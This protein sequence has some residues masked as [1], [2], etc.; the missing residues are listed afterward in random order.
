MHI[1]DVHTHLGQF[2]CSEM[3][4]DGERLCSLLRLGGITHGICF[5]GEACFGGIDLGNRYTVRE[6]EKQGMLSC[7]LVLHPH[8]YRNSVELL[9]EFADH[10]RVVGIKIHPERGLYD[11]LDR[12]LLQ[13]IEEEIA[14]RNLPILSHVSNNAPVVTIDRYLKLAAQFPE[15]HFVAAHMGTGVAGPGDTSVD[16]WSEEKPT[17]IWF[18]LGTLRAFYTGEILNL[19]KGVGADRLCFGTD[20]PL[21]WPPAF[22]R[23]LETLNLDRETYE[24]IMWKNALNVFPRLSKLVG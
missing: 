5:S 4:A 14:P 19:L 18:D 1:I 9:R 20:A 21:Y 10:P 11:V 6:V 22:T 12:H 15:L 23:T 24:K 8:H 17:N 3:S 7:L 13:L 2:H 16:A